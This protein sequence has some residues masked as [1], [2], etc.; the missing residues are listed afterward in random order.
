MARRFVRVLGVAAAGV[1]ALGVLL[2]ATASADDSIYWSREDGSNSIRFGPL[3]GST[4]AQTLF[5]DGGAPCGIA[6][7]PAAGKI[8]WAN[9]STGEIRVA[10]LDGTLG[11]ASTLFAEPGNLCGV[12]VDPAAGKIYWANFSTNE[13]RV[14]NLNGTGTASTLFTDPGGSAPSGVAIDPAN[15]KIYWTNQFSDEVRAGNLDGSGLAQ[16]LFSGED[17]PIGVAANPAAGKIYWTD[18]N[19]GTV[20]VG[21]LGGSTVGAAQTLFNSSTPSG[22]AIDPT[23]NKIY[24]TSWTSGLGIRVGNLDGTGT[25]STLFG[26]EGASLFAAILKAPVNTRLPEISG[27]AKTGKELTCQKGTWAPDLLGAFLYRAPA[28]FAYQW[29]RNGVIV[30]TNSATFMP[31]QPGD[32]TCTVMATN[33]AGSTSQT[34][35]VKKVKDK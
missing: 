20:R 1:M 16:T 3:T 5:D 12:A 11:S 8:Y 33:Q 18:L 13:I 22:P 28:S 30:G 17:N 26:G 24:W 23:T 4:P 9:W 32:Y 27:G 35:S 2:P 15:N 7:N 34:S 6:A 25:V 10:N 14:G 29:K 19:A 21:P 31:A